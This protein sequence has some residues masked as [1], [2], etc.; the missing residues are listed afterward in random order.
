MTEKDTL[1]D[2]NYDGIEE[3]DNDLPI[4]WRNIFI[5]TTVFAVF[6]AGYVHLDFAETP[7]D[8]LA[9]ELRELEELRAS[10]E[11]VKVA[12][13]GGAQLALKDIVEKPEYIE[14]GAGVFATN[15]AACHSA[16]GEGLVGPNLT[17]SH[18]IHGGMLADIR[19]VIEV[20]VPA[21]GMIPWKGVLTSEQLDQ[22]TAYVWSIRHNN[23]P[24]K[25][26]EGEPV[27]N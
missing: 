10:K 16:K 4:W 26:P 15:C 27:E 18:W 2:H 23:V 17:D 21:K 6:Y 1:L 5:I 12:E 7:H 8:K 3:Y 20:G 24:G 14:A 9:R 25:A 19:K 13:V 11:Q 22:V